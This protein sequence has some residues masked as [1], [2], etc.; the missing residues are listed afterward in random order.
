MKISSISF[1]PNYRI[2]NYQKSSKLSLEHSLSCDMVSFSASKSKQKKLK[3]RVQTAVDFSEKLAQKVR[4][5]NITINDV[6]SVVSGYTKNVTVLPMSK[7][8]DKIED[9]QNYSAFSFSKL[10]E[11]FKPSVHEIY[12]KLPS[13]NCDETELLLFAMNSAHEFTHVEQVVDLESFNMLKALSKS[14]Y[15]YANAIMSIGDRIFSFFDTIVQAHTLKPIMDRNIN[16]SKLRKYGVIVPQT[17]NVDRQMLPA[18][19]GVHSEREMQVELRKLFDSRFEQIMNSIEKNQPE[20]L[21]M[22]PPNESKEVIKKKIKSYCAQRAFDE[23]EAYT[24]ESEVA[25][26]FMKTDDM[27]N[28]DIFPMYYDVL[29]K[30]FG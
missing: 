13:E 21:E 15:D 30:A 23:R 18:A 4:E 27:L 11:D 6:E 14:N 26:K 20:V 1:V 24:T 22:F 9:A 7:L 5:G 3:P 2:Y 12:V 25:K 28:I 8:K 19:L 16:L 29:G 17:A 10:G